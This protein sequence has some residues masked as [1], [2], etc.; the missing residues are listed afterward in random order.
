MNAA[1]GSEPLLLALSPATSLGTLSPAHATLMGVGVCQHSGDR[2]GGHGK[3]RGSRMEGI[4]EACG[5]VFCFSSNTIDPE[6]LATVIYCKLVNSLPC[7]KF[8]TLL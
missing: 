3:S 8:C 7:R 4:H 2:G 1:C 6:L 5:L